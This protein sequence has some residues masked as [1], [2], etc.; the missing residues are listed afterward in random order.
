[1]EEEIDLK[2]IFN[3]FWDRKIGIIVIILLC[4]VAGYVYT[5]FFVTPVYEAT[6]TAILTSNNESS[7]DEGG[8][9]GVTQ[10]EVTLNNSLLSTYREIA[11]SDSV[12]SKVISNLGLNISDDALKSQITVTSATSSQVIQI[13]VEN[14]N[15]ELAA[16]IANEIRQVFT[17]RVAE[18]YDMQNIKSLDDAK[19]PTSPS[20]INHTKDIVMFAAIGVVLAVIYVVI[21]NLLD[22]T[23]KS[24]SDIEKATGLNVIAEIPVY[25]F[26]GRGRKR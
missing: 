5:T 19:V 14:E 6:S 10:T 26:N 7:S 23:V 17:D 12:V 20:N 24:S 11:T 8:T 22:N 25:E 1:M 15:A 2:S 21:A 16:K 13:T 4:I 9:A 3:M 18:L